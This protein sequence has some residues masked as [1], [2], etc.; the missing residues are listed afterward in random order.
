MILNIF[1]VLAGFFLLIKGADYLVDGAGSIARRLGIPALVVGLTVIAFGTSAPEL[2]VNV[3]ASFKGVTDIAV[4][5]VLGSNLANIFL[6][7]G[8]TAMVAPLTLKSNT[9]WKEVPFS[10]LAAL[11]VLVFGSDHLLG[12]GT[13]DIISR[14]EGLALL[15]F[16]FVFMVYTFGIKSDG[17]RPQQKIEIM[18]VEKSLF[19]SI[20]G[21]VALG[22]GGQIV[23]SGSVGIAAAIGL[24]TNLIA[25]TVIALGTSLP[26]LVTGVIAARKGHLD[27]AIGGVVGSNVFNIFF[28]LATSAIIHPLTFAS[29]NLVDAL[30]VLVATTVL[31]IFMFLGKAR[32]TLNRRE[33]AFFIFMYFGYIVYAVLREVAVNGGI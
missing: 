31:F 13:A 8:V 14:S 10:L 21:L 20:G 7:L 16:F 32:N 24:S 5:N 27:M 33:G 30:A 26:E 12:E 28:I 23:V 25:L 22:L 17:E 2:F 3:I 18:S 9:V 11:M 1:M 19:L 29:N 15:G 6:V 4:G